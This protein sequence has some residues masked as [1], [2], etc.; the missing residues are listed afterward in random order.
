MVLIF[1]DSETL[2]LALTSGAVPPSVSRTPVRAG[3]DANGRLLVEASVSLTRST[4]AELRR[5]GVE[6]TA[7]SDSRCAE[8]LTCWPQLLPLRL[9][10]RS[11]SRPD[12]VPILFDVPADEFASLATE[13]LRLGN[14]RQSFRVIA[15]GAGSE[16][17]LLRV[18]GPPYYS[19]LRAQ[20]PHKAQTSVA[21]VECAPRVWVQFGYLHPLGEHFKPSV[22]K[23]LLMSPPRRWTFL[24]EA[25]FRD[26]Y[27]VLN[28]D[29]PSATVEWRETE[30]SDRLRVPLRLAH[31]GG[32]EP[33][34]L[35]VLRDDAVSQLDNLVQNA[36]DKL[37][38]QL[39][40]AAGNSGE[41]LMIV[42]RV[43]PSKQPPPVLVLNAV[44]YR[45]Y[46]KLPNLFLPCGTRL[47]PPLRR[48]AVRKLLADDPADVTWLRPD[49]RSTFTPENLPDT[50]F[51]PLSEW[52]EYVL[53]R[54]REPLEQWV[55]STL[56]DFEP[57][58]C[59]EDAPPKPAKRPTP[60]SR[61]SGRP[62]SPEV[63]AKLALARPKPADQEQKPAEEESLGDLPVA[64]PSALRK[65][66]DALE[67]NFVS[68]QG[69][70]DAPERQALWP[71]LAELNAAAGHED[72]IVCW[73]HA[74]WDSNAPTFRWCNR[75]VHA[76]MKLAHEHG[77]VRTVLARTPVALALENDAIE[78]NRLLNL[79]DPTTA[80][81]RGLAAYLLASANRS[82]PPSAIRE[83]LNATRTFLE[84]HD[85]LLPVRASWLAWTSLATL[86]GNDV[87]TLARARDRLLERLYENGLRPEQ[88]L[89][90]FMR[91]GGRPGGQQSHGILRWF[92]EIAPRVHQ[93][94][95]RMNR[96]VEGWLPDRTKTKSCADLVMAYGFARIGAGELADNLV[97]MAE[98]ELCGGSPLY[99][100]IYRAYLFRI[101]QARA[102]KPL[103]GVLPETILS[104]RETLDQFE[105]YALDRLREYSRILEPDKR[106]NAYEQFFATYS[107]IEAELAQLV[108]THSPATLRQRIERLANRRELT[109]LQM[110]KVLYMSLTQAPRAGEDLALRLLKSALI[111]FDSLREN[112]HAEAFEAKAMLLEKSLL[113]AAHF[114]RSEHVEPLLARFRS[115]IGPSDYHNRE[116]CFESLAGQCLRGLRRMGLRSE[117]DT[118]LR[119]MCQ[120]L[121]ESSHFDTTSLERVR[122]HPEKL[123]ALTHVANGL[124]YFG[125]DAEA[126]AIL[127]TVRAEL[128]SGPLG[129]KDGSGSL[130]RGKLACAY[131][132]L[133]GH[134]PVEL[135]KQR[136]EEL[137]QRLESVYTSW[138][139][140]GFCVVHTRIIESV[141]LAIVSDEF[142]QGAELRRWLDDDEYLIR[143]RI[144]EDLRA[145]MSV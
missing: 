94:I 24:D 31:A 115:M 103:S 85:H 65:K 66:L 86:A 58:V 51:R 121:L 61:R 133:L 63:T 5:L 2:R 26:I 42:L 47:H 145:M 18:I 40:F 6:R 141:V 43:R 4:L 69:P 55:Q 104:Y 101:E 142:T 15:N 138:L 53:E 45:P 82:T 34:E 10:A 111:T 114:D 98:K 71:E 52:V 95:E 134:A 17:V 130:R 50:A 120:A 140:R 25:P 105:S 39:S 144:H 37:L 81:V 68:I 7:D 35:W 109:S 14:E 122:G 112:S 108:D 96:L 89:P 70:I 117:I 93:W 110:A 99:E 20:E 75:W 100:V 1:P 28:F 88:E 11:Q 135:A 76:E 84:Q 59:D 128:F 27:E 91:F 30:L 8:E 119:L 67:A 129:P 116:Q 139:T 33:A 60:Q 124:F 127:D 49:A 102:S 136:I 79:G 107:E 125:K 74:L 38:N 36:D 137:F 64:E 106:V 44:G 19:L 131:V 9:G 126:T 80:E 46:L 73:L 90:S 123:A 48:D 143:K 57:F 13:L 54:E 56:F 3:A 32:T 132:S 16:H 29:L 78:L 92:Q 12:Q 77:D 72:A 97:R 23:L 21:Y 118:L 62:K 22:G 83:R 41:E 87:L 113:V